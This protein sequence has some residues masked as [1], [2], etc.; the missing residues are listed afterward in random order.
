MRFTYALAFFIALYAAPG[1]CQDTSA[2]FQIRH[3]PPKGVIIDK[4]WK[5]QSGDQPD[6]AR[7]DYDDSSWEGI[8]PSINIFA[9]PLNKT[10]GIC[11]LRVHV[12]LD[13]Q[14][15]NEQVA[16]LIT[17][18]VASEVYVNG[19]LIYKFGV[20]SEDPNKIQ[21][22]IPSLPVILPTDGKTD[23]V[24]ALRYVALPEFNYYFD[25]NVQIP[26]LEI[27]LYSANNAFVQVR[28]D[29]RHIPVTNSFRIGAV[30]MLAF[31]YMAFFLYNPSRTAYLFFFLYVFFM[32]AGDVLQ[33]NVPPDIRTLYFLV[34]TYYILWQL[35]GLFLILA[36]YSLLN[37][38]K[39]LVFWAMIIA[40]CI[41]FFFRSWVYST[42][43]LGIVV[44]LWLVRISF[45]ASQHKMRGA[46]I[47]AAGALG[48]MLGITAFTIGARYGLA[49][50]YFPLGDAY[51][52][53]D[54]LYAVG[55]LS[56][57][58]A[59]TIYVAL[60]FAFTNQ[61][62]SEKLEEVELLSK[63]T[64][65]QEKEKRQLLSS[66]NTTLEK[67]VAE[68][69]S[70]LNQSLNNLKAT[71]AQLIQ[72]EKMASLGELTAGIA[73]E[74]ENPLN[75]VNNFSEVSNELMGELKTELASGNSGQAEVLA[76]DIMMNLEKI[77]HH[78]KRADAIVKNMLQHSRTSSGKKESTDINTL[79][80]EYLRLAYHG[81]RA[82]D[83]SFN[84][85]F[86]TQLDPSLPK[87]NVVSQDIGRVILNLINNAFYAV[88]EKSKSQSASYEPRI[89]VATKNLGDKIEISVE[90]NGSGVPDHIKEKIFQPFFTTKPAGQG[91]GLG[92]SLSY[93]IVKA[94]G[95]T[96]DVRSNPG[97]TVFTLQ[98]PVEEIGR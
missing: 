11:W 84:A 16:A 46:W 33:V 17:Q 48:S 9:Q 97:Q 87:V 21:A 65:E 96:I 94:N 72:S 23:Y 54:I 73:H 49:Y 15:R 6:Y 28:N 98:L 39:G 44:S 95:G 35:S 18:Y 27:K 50:W 24:I 79:C 31:L 5:F 66:L 60:D 55:Q 7:P 56:I 42:F 76:N 13:E 47:I 25:G 88:N 36:M 10:S 86:N 59:T 43:F 40:V 75:F 12:I 26:L 92:L 8:N 1:V 78:G 83:K 22:Y 19:K 71:Q 52:F 62:L 82:K 69:T 93:D 63:K 77:N 74:I 37:Q 38:K 41:G 34:K 20:V 80:D 30:V 2:I 4:G 89:I 70:E 14:L 61:R 91:T 81:Y 90:D 85:A 32:I 51:I 58:I 29:N 57:P 3:F 53:A 68:R 45:K 67:Q 64:S